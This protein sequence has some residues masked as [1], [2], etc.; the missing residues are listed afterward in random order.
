MKTRNKYN[1]KVI[2]ILALLL[3][4]NLGCERE[5]SDNA[6]EASFSTLGEIFT[7]N[8][9]G[10]GSDFYL[11]F[12]DSKLDAFSVDTNEGF[13]SSASFRVDVPNANDPTGSY[14]G[15]ILRI[16]GAGRDLRG[17]DALTFYAKA[18]QGVT[19][20]QVGFGQDFME[21]KYQVSASGISVGTNW[22]KYVIPIPDASKL[23]EER[24][25][26]WYAAGTQATGGFGYVVWFDEIRFE[27]LGTV[28][29]PRPAILEGQDVVEQTFIGSNRSV[30]GL[31]QTFNLAN[32][33]DMTVSAAPSYFE[34]TSSNPSVATV[35]N[36]GQVSIVGSGETVIT[37]D[38]GGLD[39]EGSLTLES[40]GE[41]TPAPSPPAREPQNVIS[42]FSDAYTNVPVDYY[43]G[44][45]APFQTTQG[46]APPLNIAG[47]QVIN[48]TELNFVGIGTF[49]NVPTVN[50]TAMTHFHVDINVQEAIDPSDFIRLQLINNVGG[51]EVS[52]SY[53]I[54]ASELVS[55]GWAS[56]DVPLSQFT[57]L[58]ERDELGLIFFI[59]D[60]TISNIYV[61]NV[62]YYKDVLDP[63]PNVDDSAATQVA[64]P[65][66]FESTTLTYNFVGFEGAD[67]AIIAN[68]DPSGIN[69]TANVMRTIKTN[70]S[71]FFA[72]TFLDLDAPIDLS[73]SQKL[74][75]KVWSPKA[76]IP[77]RVA[78]ETAGGGNQIFIDAN[79]TTSN[80][81]EE[82]EFDYSGVYNPSLDYQRVIVFFEFIVNLPGD[83]ST[84][85][86][87]D[88]QILI[89]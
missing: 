34:F 47:N 35:S 6:V 68:P 26:F 50:A 54:P 1:I 36:L 78:L 55:N 22:A 58:N 60:A 18:S 3:A 49:L 89:E 52:G 86:Y 44:F 79:T 76:N 51:N 20:D 39:A 31:Q 45:F 14:A 88:L 63:T 43:N 74:R 66:G 24:G 29:Q 42:V 64:F 10:M 7:D 9:V 40:L 73:T 77:I 27:N 23:M 56:F 59:S 4:F 37:A 16:D 11:P 19:I 69:P 85:Y 72:G 82:L 53:T 8:F 13:E 28:A 33:Q 25:M 21:N 5:I 32:G 67:S 61:D 41:F 46:G 80:E 75:M 62:Y 48:Y 15:A 12:A 84:Y 71:Q 2:G 83:G 81:W 30:T 65:V 38:L 17:Y 70:G 87:D 57:G